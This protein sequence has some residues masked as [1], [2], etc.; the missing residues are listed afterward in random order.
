MPAPYTDKTWMITKGD[1]AKMFTRWNVDA[2]DIDCPT[3]A[4]SKEFREGDPSREVSLWYIHPNGETKTLRCSNFPRPM[5]NARAIFLT[6]DSI[7]QAEGRGLGD[8]LRQ[9]YVQIPERTGPGR[10]PAE[11][12]RRAYELLGLEVTA[13]D[14]EVSR[15]YKI[16]AKRTHPD[17]EGGSEE[18]FRRVNEALSVIQASRV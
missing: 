15:G 3:P 13:S 11:N 4:H 9:N 12:I 6:L 8:L 1:L 16:A 17:V 14:E 7:R 2:W 18:K 5:D 10:P